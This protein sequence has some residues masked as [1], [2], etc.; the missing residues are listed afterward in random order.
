MLALSWA[1]VCLPSYGDAPAAR[2][3]EQTELKP[4][5]EKGARL[6]K[7]ASADLNGDGTTDY[8]LVL[9]KQKERPDDPG[10]G[11]RQRPLLILVRDAKEALEQVKRND[12]IISCHPSA[13]LYWL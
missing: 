1:A 6:V 2:V 4:F 10:M 11:E 12:K 13:S 7:I 5:I 9:E 3:S 8:I